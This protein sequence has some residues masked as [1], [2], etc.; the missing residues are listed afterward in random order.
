MQDRSSDLGDVVEI[1][2]DPGENSLGVR[3]TLFTTRFPLSTALDFSLPATIY[4]DSRR[5]PTLG[6]DVAPAQP[7]DGSTLFHGGS[8]HILQTYPAPF[9]Y[10]IEQSACLP[11]GRHRAK[12][13]YQTLLS[14]QL[15]NLQEMQSP[16]CLNLK[17]PH[18]AKCI[19]HSVT[20]TVTAKDGVFPPTDW[21]R[22][23]RVR[24]SLKNKKPIPF[25]KKRSKFISRPYTY[26]MG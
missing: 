7:L 9:S 6:R 5:P 12:R 20:K 19:A 2:K 26:S 11:A 10:S 13:K 14:G 1:Y 4:P 15:L 17:I 24:K 23:R 25:P 16:A 18:R 21:G 3:P 8:T 22:G